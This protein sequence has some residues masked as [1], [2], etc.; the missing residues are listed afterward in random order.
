VSLTGAHCHPTSHLSAHSDLAG[1]GTLVALVGNANTGKSTLFNQLSGARASV[2]N[3]PGTTVEVGTAAWQVP[4]ADGSTRPLALMDLPG[5]ASLTP[6]S[7]DEQVTHD[8]LV[9]APSQE[10]PDVVVAVLD[11]ANLGRDLFLLSQLREQP[12]RLVVALTM[13]DIAARRGLAV[14][15]AA[16]SRMAG[17]PVV[18]VDPRRRSGVVGLADAVT[19]AADAAA[20]A[21]RAWVL[22]GPEAADPA[23]PFAADDDR[24]AWVQQVLDGAVRTEHDRVPRTDRVDRWATAPVIGPLLFA[25]AMYLVFQITIAGAAPL[26]D[27]LDSWTAGPVSEAAISLLSAVGLAGGALESFVVDGLI[28]GVGTLLTF[29]PLMAIMFALLAILESSGYLAR[30]AVVTD[31][32]MRA[33]GLPGRAFLPL[34]VGF[35]CNV[36]AISAIRVLPDARQRLLTALLVPFTLCAARLPVVVLVGVAFFGSEAGNVVFGMYLLSIVLVIGVGLV[37]R[38]TLWRGLRPT[39]M[40]IDLPPYHLPLPRQITLDTWARV[41]SFLRAAGTIIVI[42]VIAVWALSAIPAP[43]ADAPI[44]EVPVEDS[45]YGATARAL[46]PVFEPAGFGDWQATS[47]LMVGFLAKEAVISSWAQTYAAEEPED[48]AEPGDLSAS[49]RADFERSSGGHTTAAVFAFLTFL[50]AYTPCVATLGAQRREIGTRWMLTSVAIST[51]TA[52]VLAVLVFQIGRLL[53]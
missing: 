36:P 20:P 7:P 44:T 26:Q 41:R 34:I 3:W 45:L 46:S 9:K 28:A 24:F 27:W 38:A 51:G 37:L 19:Q 33:I 53:T 29:V 47:A 5:A 17:V 49:L 13:N 22:T 15:T 39:P 14:D 16:L 30:A 23:D 18:A 50:V 8:L 42:V 10:R 25:G 21:P 2:G 35:G 48:P 40:V 11:A 1:D 6:V 31:R 12:Q 4:L 32:A 43:G 52:W